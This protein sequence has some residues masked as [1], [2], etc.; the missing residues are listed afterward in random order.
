[1]RRIGP[2]GDPEPVTSELPDPPGPAPASRPVRWIALAAVTLALLV[3][4]ALVL[5]YLT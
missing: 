4:A 5:L 1:V 2:T 3:L